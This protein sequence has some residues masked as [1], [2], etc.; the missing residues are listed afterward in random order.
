MSG[1]RG[2]VANVYLVRTYRYRLYPT[3]AQAVALNAQLAA[4]CDLYN[5]ALEHRRTLWREHG[6]SV[7][8]GDQS[9]ELRA[10]RAEGLLL[11]DANFWCQQHTLRRLDRAFTAFFAR[12]KT[13][14]KAGY[15]RFKSKRRFDTLV[16][17]L[18]GHAGGVAVKNGRLAL[19][20]VGA[21]KVKWHR[22]LPDDATLGEV[23]V[24][25]ASDG[26]RWH[27]SISVEL[28]DPD[29]RQHPHPDAIVGIDLGV[30]DFAAFSTGER[31]AGPQA[32]KRNA[33]ATRRA[34]RT[35]ARRKH[36]SSR[37]RK[38]AV[39]LARHREREA[40]RRRDHAHKLSCRIASQF[41]LI[42][43]EALK[44]ANMLRSASGTLTEPG[45]GVA[46]KRGLNRSISDQGWSQ[47][48]EFVA[49][50][51]EE[52]GGQTIKV[53]PAHTSQTCAQCGRV[54][55][56]SRRGKWFRCTRCGHTADADVNAA[57]A[58]LARALA[59]AGLHRPGCGRQ[60][61]TPALADVA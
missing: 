1:P 25:R 9:A 42:G 19:Q 55:P 13:G 56:S 48:A 18:K 45:A 5:A 7:S 30:R 41:A 28:A 21:V 32:S 50:K 54:D 59:Q 36:G 24:T 34:A 23:K 14:E 2:S 20:G 26:R 22:A 3:R 8:Y 47:F 4:C 60:A 16:W 27:V 39:V 6:V 53:N 37:R 12:L 11:A 58:I 44:I 31:V 40:N 57:Q 10:L 33:A 35:V 15:P 43:I 17:T 61:Q 46:H 52:A 38:A 51:A 49:Y 29:E